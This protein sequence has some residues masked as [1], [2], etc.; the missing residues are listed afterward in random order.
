M[1]QPQEISREEYLKRKEDMVQHFEEQI[2][3]L[4]LQKKYQTLLTEIEELRARYVRAQMMIAQAIAPP[5][6]EVEET[7]DKPVRPLKRS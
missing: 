1:E 5:P 6:E 3:F 7:E 2:P 4:E